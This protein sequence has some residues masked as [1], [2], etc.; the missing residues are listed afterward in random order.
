MKVV[1]DMN[2]SP[3]WGRALEGRGF[4]VIMWHS[5]GDPRAPDR[6]ILDWARNQGYVVFTNDLDFSHLLALTY[7]RGPS[8]LQIRGQ[9]LL[10][11]DTLETVV[12]ALTQCQEAMRAGA[13]VTVDETTRRVRSLPIKSK[14]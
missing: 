10:P 13:L 3:E 7:A 1:I 6:E 2:L 8:V 4:E 11:E 9:G 12:A 5:V 14:E